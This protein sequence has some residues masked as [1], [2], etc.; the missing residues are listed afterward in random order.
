MEITLNMNN[1]LVFKLISNL[2][3]MVTNYFLSLDLIII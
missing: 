2:V 3:N 1:F